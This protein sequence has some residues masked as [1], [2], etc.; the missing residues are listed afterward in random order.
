LYHQSTRSSERRLLAGVSS[1]ASCV[2]PCRGY[3]PIYCLPNV[4]WG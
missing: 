4:A 1:S 2:L 3:Q